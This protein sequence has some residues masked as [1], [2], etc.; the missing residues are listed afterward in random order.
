MLFGIDNKP[1]I[2]T[3]TCN[4]CMLIVIFINKINDA[5]LCIIRILVVIHRP[6]T[7]A[8][9][10]EGNRILTA[11]TKNIKHCEGSK[12]RKI[13]FGDSVTYEAGTSHSIVIY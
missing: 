2:C 10:D 12:T 9:S 3:L 7:N 13:S 1:Q 6:R 8:R 4:I 5:L 11:P